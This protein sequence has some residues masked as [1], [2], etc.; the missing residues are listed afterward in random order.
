MGTM[1]LVILDRDGILNQDSAEFIKNGSA[2]PAELAGWHVITTSPVWDA[3]CL[4]YRDPRQDAQ[5]AGGRRADV[6]CSNRTRS[7]E[8]QNR[9]GL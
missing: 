6:P 9:P 4:M 5:N 1:K 8:A 3:V 7:D 2:L